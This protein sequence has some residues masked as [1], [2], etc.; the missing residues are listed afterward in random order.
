VGDAAEFGADCVGGEAGPEEAAI[1]GSDF[2]LVEGA[3]QVGEASLDADANERGFVGF[4]EDGFE[5]GFDVLIGNAAGAKFAGD[6]E[7][8]LAAQFGVLVGVVQGVARVVE[9]VKFAESGDDRR[10]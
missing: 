1:K 5:G 2:A 7:A 8:S 3:A 6:T 10:D 9:V 4:G